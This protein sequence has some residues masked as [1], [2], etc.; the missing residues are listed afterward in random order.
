MLPRSLP[1]RVAPFKTLTF[2]CHWLCP[3]A[4]GNLVGCWEAEVVSARFVASVGNG[5]AGG[6]ERVAVGACV[7]AGGA[8]RDQLPKVA[9]RLEPAE[10]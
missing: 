5:C 2:V 1:G 7:S 3:I 4:S 9:D 6:A 10:K 8:M